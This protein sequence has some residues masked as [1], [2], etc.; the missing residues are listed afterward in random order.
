MA[1]LFSSKLNEAK[2]LW[3]RISVNYKII[4]TAEP[5]KTPA[6]SDESSAKEVLSNVWAVGIAQW[7]KDTARAMQLL[8]Y[9]LWPQYLQPTIIYWRQA[10]MT[11]YLESFGQFF[12][13][14]DVPL[15]EKLLG[16]PRNDF[17]EGCVFSKSLGSKIIFKFIFH[18][19]CL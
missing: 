16:L 18:V 3:K 8:F 13:P 2:Y 17:E 14:I 9:S 10:L 15:L 11:S 7:Q 6:S 4:E 5:P 19:W 12:A 1:L